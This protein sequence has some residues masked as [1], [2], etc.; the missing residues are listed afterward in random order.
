MKKATRNSPA[1]NCRPP[2]NLYPTPGK[3][4]G[5]R[6]R[7]SS[8]RHG[9]H[10]DSYDQCGNGFVDPNEK[11]EFDSGAKQESLEHRVDHFEP[12]SSPSPCTQTFDCC[13]HSKSPAPKTPKSY[14]LNTP[15]SMSPMSN[16]KHLSL[17]SPKVAKSPGSSFSHYTKSANTVTL[18]SLTTQSSFD[19]SEMKS[20]ASPIKTSTPKSLKTV[21]L[22]V[23]SDT[24]KIEERRNT[25]G[26]IFALKS[27]M[28]SPKVILSP[29]P[30][31]PSK[32]LQ[33]P[34][35][36]S[37]LPFPEMPERIFDDCPVV[38]IEKPSP[39]SHSNLYG[40]LH[41]SPMMS[42]SSKDNNGAFGNYKSQQEA[43]V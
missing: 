38:S 39:P 11:N 14:D 28:M 5:S 33:S 9:L 4:H 15:T 7:K 36:S 19:S 34:T 37:Y 27:P 18:T 26:S 2:I 3:L 41:I 35:K 13:S 1:K 20:I 32:H 30:H 21:P 12:S 29:R 25:I 40:N 22:T 42:L 8:S 6:K 43:Y 23:I 24:K 10:S 16:L 17:R 31:R